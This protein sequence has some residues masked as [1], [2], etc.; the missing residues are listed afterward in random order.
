M[1]ELKI[2]RENRSGC[3]RFGG[4]GRTGREG[5]GCF[6]RLHN[7]TTAS[8]PVLTT[9][10]KRYAVCALPEG[11]IYPFA[12]EKLG[13]LCGDGRLFY[14]GAEVAGWDIADTGADG[15]SVV[16]LGSRAVFFPDKVWFDT[17]SGEFGRLEFSRTSND[18]RATV[19]VLYTDGVYPQ[20]M[21]YATEPPAEPVDNAL[22]VRREITTGA[23]VAYRWYGSLGEWERQDRLCYRVSFDFAGSDIKQGDRM[24]ITACRT[25]DAEIDGM[26]GLHRVAT[27]EHSAVGFEA[28]PDHKLLPRICRKVSHS[29]VLTLF[30]MERRIPDLGLICTAGER[31]WGVDADG[32]TLRASAPGDPFSW[33]A[34]DGYGGDSFAL[35]TAYPG[36]FTAIAEHKGLPVFFKSDMILYLQGSRPDNYSLR[37]VKGV[38]AAADSPRGIASAGDCLYYKAADG[39]LCRRSADGVERICERPLEGSVQAVF[40]GRSCVFSDAVSFAVYDTA[41]DALSTEDGP[42]EAFL[43]HG[44]RIHYLQ[45]ADGIRTL[46]RI[47]GSGGTPAPDVEW[48]LESTDFAPIDGFGAIPRTLA[49]DIESDGRST[50]RVDFG[51]DGDYQN[52]GGFC[53]NGRLRRR[54]ELPARTCSVCSYR[55]SGR[56]NFILREAEVSAPAERRAYG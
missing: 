17:E 39:Y 45:N 40:D 26:I 50:V 41:T 51:W 8:H 22:W 49:L 34:F 31:I 53:F 23:I 47:G 56:G 1:N 16:M 10:E 3:R 38:G 44:G 29:V 43:V 55:I 14:D 35:T 19:S 4:I 27:V 37:A 42:A 54:I 33:F 25:D 6:R 11:E 30:T 36:R 7:L 24:E 13:W 18:S 52:V 2:P 21:T 12:A 9:A 20:S 28:A 48:C 5:I 32:C 15:H 46:Y